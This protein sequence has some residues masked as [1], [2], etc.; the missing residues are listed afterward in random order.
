MNWNNIW[1]TIVNF[2][3]D[4]I[5]NIAKFFAIFLIGLIVI[6]ILLNI[7]RRLFLKSKIEKMALNFIYML[8]KF[9]L[10]FLLTLALLNVV[11][12]ELNGVLTA[13]SAVVLAIGM[14]LESNIAN[15]ANG[16]VI[17]S[18]Q[19]FKK[20]DF[21]TIGDISGSVQEIHFL[22]TT[23]IT[24]DNKKITIPNSTIVNSA[25]VNAGAN[26]TRRVDFTF[27]V[28]YESDVEKVKEIVKNVMISNGKVYLDPAPFCRLKT[29]NSSSLDFFANCWCDAEDYW[30]VY[31]Y[32]LENVYNE[33][34]RENVSVPYNQIEVRNRLDEVKMPYNASP[35]PE[36]VE[37]ERKQ[38]KQH[39]DLE[40]MDLGEII[41]EQTKKVK[42]KKKNNKNQKN[43]N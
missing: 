7:I 27:S 42:E 15:F 31:Y 41:K 18:M 39:F 3:K 32:V 13:F 21:L 23:L 5:F 4:N 40:T 19:M 8:I 38:E 33:F 11:G 35:L 1:N 29:L 6:K 16:I 26:K 34:K 14:A 2:F 24:T 20:G 22:F 30:D 10:Y 25:V 43:A 17:V 37:K 36:R 28:A 9:S 12:I